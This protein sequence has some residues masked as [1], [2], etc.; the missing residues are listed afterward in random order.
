M[1]ISMNQLMDFVVAQGA[2]DLHI[3]VGRKPTIRKS[4]HLKDVNA[5][6]LT[7]AD[8]VRLMKEIAP[9]KALKEL[10]AD[11]SADWGY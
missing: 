3:A 8:S 9:E 2:S 6:V 11:G 10:Q 5:P 4:G 7:P 1:A